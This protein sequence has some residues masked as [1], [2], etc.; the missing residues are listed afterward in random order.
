MEQQATIEFPSDW[1]DYELIDSGEGMKLERFDSYII[2]RPDP[3]AIW[4]KHNPDIWHRAD[5]NFI[6]TSPTEGN[7]DITTPPPS[8]WTISYNNLTFILKPTSFKHV[9]VFPE[10]ATN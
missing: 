1:K 6:R 5:A 3:R 2:A 8:P 10:Q 7:W 9:G 4:S